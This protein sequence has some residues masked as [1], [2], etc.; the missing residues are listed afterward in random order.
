M[1]SEQSTPDWKEL[2][3]RLDIITSPTQHET[4]DLCNRKWW[5]GNVRKLKT[6][7]IRGHVFGSVLH[8]VAER[9][10]RADDLGRDPATGLPVDLYPEGWHRSYNKYTGE[11]EGEL[12]PDEQDRLRRM[13]AEAIQ[14]G[15]LERQPN[16]RVEREFRKQ[17]LE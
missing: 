8:A 9:Y 13:V 7:A 6:P 1:T 17:V 3:K 12:T 2:R 11:L 4:F 14:A 16:R 15:V 5:L 10:L